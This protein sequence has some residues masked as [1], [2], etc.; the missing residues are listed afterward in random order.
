[1]RIKTVE[2]SGGGVP[3]FFAYFLSLQK[4]SKSDE[5][6]KLKEKLNINHG[7]REPYRNEYWILI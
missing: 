5:K 3:A 2:V 1:M 4:E 6:K 7:E